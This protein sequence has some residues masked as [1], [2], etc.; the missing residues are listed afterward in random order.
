MGNGVPSLHGAVNN[1][2]TQTKTD[3]IK[4]VDN[5]MEICVYTVSTENSVRDTRISLTHEIIS[6]PPIWTASFQIKLCQL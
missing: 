4:E 5:V 1:E 2:I 3:L 6:F